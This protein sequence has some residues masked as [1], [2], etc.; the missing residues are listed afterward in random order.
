VA[1]SVLM[2]EDGHTRNRVTAVMK[3]LS[4]TA[5]GAQGGELRPNAAQQPD[6]SVFSTRWLENNVSRY[7][8]I[9]DIY[10]TTMQTSIQWGLRGAESGG[11]EDRVVA[12]RGDNR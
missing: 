11:T 6:C 7:N 4:C 8:M 1:V 9:A 12:T 3:Y 10:T 2:R 5:S